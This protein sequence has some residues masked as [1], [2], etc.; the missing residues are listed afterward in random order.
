MQ[1]LSV[2]SRLDQT[3]AAVDGSTTAVKSSGII[4]LVAIVNSQ[5]FIGFDNF[6]GE[7]RDEWEPFIIASVHSLG[8][9]I[10]FAGMLKQN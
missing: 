4:F 8:E 9:Q 7:E 2:V 10:W 1:Q 6:L 5:L 3:A